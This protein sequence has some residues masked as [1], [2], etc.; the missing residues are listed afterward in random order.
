M[1]GDTGTVTVELRNMASGEVYV[2]EDDE[3]FDMNAYIASATLEGN[4]GIKILDGRQ[5]DVGLLGPGDYIRL[6][7][8][9]Q[10]NESAANGMHFLELEVVGGSNMYNLNYRIPVKVDDKDLKIIVSD[11]PPTLMKEYSIV[12]VEV[13]NLRSNDITG[14]IVTPK[15]NDIGFFPTNVFVGT[16]NGGNKSTAT[17]TLNTMTSGKGNK[18]MQFSTTYFN[19]DNLHIS[20]DTNYNIEVVDQPALILST[21]EIER[22][23]NVYSITGDINNFGTTDTKNVMIS[24]M[25][26]ENITPVQP[27]EKYF[28]GTL[29]SDDFSSF[30]LSA[31]TQGSNVEEI[32]LLIE[33]RNT[34]NA[35]A[36][37]NENIALQKGMVPESNDSGGMSFV[38][39]GLIAVICIAV[40]GVIA[41]SWKKRKNSE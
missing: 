2:Q 27:Y 11:M 20:S 15:G 32:P 39:I 21:I 8:N 18:E 4:K 5:T 30:E 7:F 24:V 28:V 25:E 10:A 14:V 9:I 29:E 13:V 23:G 26:T 38:M 16:I 33:F 35:Y 22:T 34:N 6:T 40:L 1:P 17:F 31:S 36:Y 37:I 12:N 41:Y 19:G 3:T